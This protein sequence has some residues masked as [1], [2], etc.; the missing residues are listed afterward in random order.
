MKSVSKT[1]DYIINEFLD[2]LKRDEIPWERGWKQIHHVNAVSNYKY[3]GI[4]RFILSYVSASLKYNDPRWITFNQVKENNWKLKDAKGKGV[5]IEFWSPYDTETKKKL[6][7]D[8]AEEMLKD[9]S[10]RDR[11]KFICKVYYVFNASLVDGMPPY[12]QEEIEITNTAI[13]DFLSN[14]IENEKILI[15]FANEAYYEPKKDEIYMPPRSSFKK[16]S[17]YFDTFFHEIAHSTGS[18]K[19]LNRD[20]SGVF[21]STNYAKEELRAEIASSFIT[22]ELGLEISDENMNRHKAYIQSWISV[23]EKNPNE[24]FKAIQDADLITNYIKEKGDFEF[25]LQD[26]NVLEDEFI[27]QR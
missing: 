19:R 20:L 3:K 25:I 2:S 5:P 7:N 22:A 14:Y 18:K 21:G 17:Y 11:V 1:R 9:D 15:L 12:E 24:L 26:S 10:T 27:A 23:L 13:Q 8:E 6:T 16:E 4:N